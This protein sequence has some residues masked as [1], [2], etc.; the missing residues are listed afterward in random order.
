MLMLTTNRVKDFDEAIHSRVS[1]AIRYPDM[2][3]ATRAKVWEN[4]LNAAGVRGMDSWALARLA[5]LDGR[6]IKNLIPMAL[7]AAKREGVPAE[8]RHVEACLRM[9]MQFDEAVERREATS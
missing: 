7:V 3:E 2:D 8:A 4:L 9:R 1:L 5:P 6:E